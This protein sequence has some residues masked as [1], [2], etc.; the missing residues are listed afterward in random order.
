MRKDKEEK[1]K[2]APAVSSR[3]T[4]RYKGVTWGE[5]AADCFSTCRRSSTLL[6]SLYAE[7]SFLCLSATLAE[8]RE[9]GGGVVG[10][11]NDQCAQLRPVA[12][13]VGVADAF[14]VEAKPLQSRATIVRI[15]ACRFLLKGDGAVPLKTVGRITKMSSLRAMWYSYNSWPRSMS[16]SN[17]KCEMGERTWAKFA[18]RTVKSVSASSPSR[19]NPAAAV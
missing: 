3:S 7:W 9:L 19:D 14:H 6:T 15:Y 16:L 5:T 13:G 4:T 12:V 8:Y 11:V 1:E 17:S 10:L 18:R 2:R